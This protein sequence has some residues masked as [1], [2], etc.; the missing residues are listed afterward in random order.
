[1]AA[2]G[3]GRMYGTTAQQWHVY[4]PKFCCHGNRICLWHHPAA[5]LICLGVVRGVGRHESP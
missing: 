3:K 4:A 1:M 2:L 5:C